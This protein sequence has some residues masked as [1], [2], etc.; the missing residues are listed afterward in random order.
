MAELKRLTLE[1]FKCFKDKT[2]V[3]FGKLT[4]LTGAN[5]SGKSSVIFGVLGAL[6][7]GE[8]PLLFSTNGDYVNMGDYQEVVF[9]HD[10]KQKIS[11]GLCITNP[12][13]ICISSTW[14]MDKQNYLPLLHSFEI[15]GPNYQLKV[16]RVKSN[17][18]ADIVYQLSDEDRSE[19]HSVVE[20]MK[21]FYQRDMKDLE[22]Q[23]NDLRNYF[24]E[25]IVNG[26][27]LDDI[28]VK[29]SYQ[30]KPELRRINQV[31]Y[32]TVQLLSGF[33]QKINYI[34]SFRYAPQRDY[35]E[36]TNRKL[37]VLASGDGYLDQLIQWETK[38]DSRFAKVVAMARELNLLHE[39][40]AKRL[41]GGRYEMR[42]KIRKDGAESSLS[43]VGFGVS[44]F[45]PIIVADLQLPDDSTLFVSQP[46]IHL[47]P[48]IQSL[49]GDYLIKQS[50]TD[51]NYV[52]ETHSEYLLNKLRLGIV[53]GELNPDDIRVYFIDNQ[54][55]EAKLHKIEFTPDGQILNAPED[56]FKTYM[57]DVLDIAIHATK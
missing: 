28:P 38:K 39:V 6:Q 15:K 20:E 12:E 2:E 16:K 23:I 26:V 13:E 18:E 49:F 53:K 55:G 5:S 52:I 31:F 14:E 44:Q 29:V 21:H 22:E 9:D 19:E 41:D 57:M 34:S 27:K 50:K 51:K 10:V 37:K 30:A 8:F 36:K 47:H 11:L 48:N 24:R 32:Q 46:E 1:N 4:L 25:I 54:T 33:Q 56:F 45:L 43:D 35:L 17:Y 42:V 3:E 40:M 7:S